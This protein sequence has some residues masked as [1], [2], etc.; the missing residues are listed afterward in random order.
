MMLHAVG[1]V[2]VVGVQRGCCVGTANGTASIGVSAQELQ[3]VL[4][5]ALPW[6]GVD[7]STSARAGFERC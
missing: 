6:A 7:V 3:G 5:Q 4:C 1:A 2:R